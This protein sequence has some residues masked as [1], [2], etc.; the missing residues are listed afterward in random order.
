M[1]EKFIEKELEY[2]SPMFKQRA[3]ISDE[4]RSLWRQ[5]TVQQRTDRISKEAFGMCGGSVRYGPFTGLSLSEDTWWCAPHLGSQCFGLYEKEIIDFIQS[6]DKRKERLFVDIGAAD[7]YYVTGML[8]GGFAKEAKCF[9]S[10]NE[11]QTSI[12][13]NWHKNGCPGKLEIYG[14]AT[15]ESVLNLELG[16]F[17]E[18]V[19][20][21]DIEGQEF[22]LL[23]DKVI[24]FLSNCQ[25]IIEIHNWIEGFEVKYVDLLR[26]LDNRFRIRVLEHQVRDTTKMPELR[27]F[28]DDNRLL[29]TSEKR[30]CAM[31]YIHLSPKV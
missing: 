19:V 10:S 27:S 16:S 18:T 14:E 28:S 26:R 25:I 3:D 17:Q 1:I 15:P 9:E 11:G 4:M 20:L 7:G 5:E 13:K 22:E 21:V 2:F 24:E 31:R 8:F 29:L 6:L 30:P 23:N 12:L